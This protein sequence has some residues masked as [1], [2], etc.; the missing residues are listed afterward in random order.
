MR[1]YLRKKGKDDSSWKV[2]LFVLSADN[3]SLSYYI[4]DQ[5]CDLTI[6]QFSILGFLTVQKH[7]AGYSGQNVSQLKKVL[8]LDKTMSHMLFPRES[9]V[10][11]N[12]FVHLFGEATF[13]T[14]MYDTNVTL[15]MI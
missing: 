15:L 5:V 2:R 1:G 14:I 3:N 10:Y 12:L 8:H 11:F 9:R 4:K 6:N 13:C 7:T